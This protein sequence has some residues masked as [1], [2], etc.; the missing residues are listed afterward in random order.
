MRIQKHKKSSGFALGTF[1]HQGF[2]LV[3]LL[4]VIAIIAILVTI[5]LPAVNAAREAARRTQ[6]INNMKQIGLALHGFHSARG[7]FPPGFMNETEKIPGRGPCNLAVSV[8]CDPQISYMVHLYPYLEYQ[9]LYDQMDFEK[10]WYVPHNPFLPGSNGWPKAALESNIPT[11]LCPSDD[12]PTNVTCCPMIFL[13]NYLAFF[14]GLKHGDIAAYEDNP[15]L[16]PSGLAPLPDP[17]R[18]RFRAVFGIDRGA[19]ISQITDGTSKTLVFSE[20]LRGFTSRGMFWTAHAGR[21]ILFT[22]ET[23]N[24]SAPDVLDPSNCG[25][26][27]PERNLPCRRST[28]SFAQDQTAAARSRHTGGVVALLADG[29]VHFIVDDVDLTIWR[30]STTIAGG[31]VNDPL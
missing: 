7:S 29:S 23:P 13:A 8:Y 20:H 10:L 16:V 25:E 18:R 4:V 9:D 19:K 14:S 21:A 15:E 27:L 26:S 11:L 2:T 6:C 24:S 5:L 3:E 28:D 17:P 31:E 12:G 22:M 30:G 1:R